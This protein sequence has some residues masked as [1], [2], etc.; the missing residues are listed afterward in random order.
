MKYLLI[1]LLFVPFVVISL[2]FGVIAWLWH[3]TKD[4]FY[5][6]ARLLDTLFN[7]KRFVPRNNNIVRF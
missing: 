3:P 4:Q 2:T 6:G 7:L 1:F 5:K